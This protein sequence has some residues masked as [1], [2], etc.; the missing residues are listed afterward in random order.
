MKELFL[1][2]SL[3]SLLS[4]PAPGA[5]AQE[6]TALVA[7]IEKALADKEP[8]WRIVPRSP[9]AVSHTIHLKSG[10]SHALITV[11][12]FDSA[13]SAGEAFEGNTI[14]FGNTAGRRGRKTSLPKFADEN[15]MWTGFSA[16]ATTSIHFRQGEVYVNLTAPSQATAK[17]FAR[18]AL[19]QVVEY[20]KAP[21]GGREG[22]R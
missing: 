1:S 17:R 13:K 20:Q 2:F 7:R 18:H 3:L 6:A 22:R 12:V 8:R 9:Q 14:A 4:W 21:A 11:F 10:N 16:G 5:P 19:E 15:L